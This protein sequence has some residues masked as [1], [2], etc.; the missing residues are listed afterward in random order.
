MHCSRPHVNIFFRTYFTLLCRTNPKDKA[1]GTRQEKIKP[2]KIR[3]HL[4]Y[5]PFLHCMKHM[6]RRNCG[7]LFWKRQNLFQSKLASEDICARQLLWSLKFMYAME[8]HL[9][10]SF[11]IIWLSLKTEPNGRLKFALSLPEAMFHTSCVFP[12]LGSTSLCPCVEASNN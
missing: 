12:V 8:S 2:I 9:A 4:V 11:Y 3:T 5:I 10:V 1:A 6:E 7:E